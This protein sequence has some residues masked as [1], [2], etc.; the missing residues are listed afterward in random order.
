[1]S[2]RHS[3]LLLTTCVALIASAALLLPTA[4]QGQWTVPR[5]S[6]GHPDLQGN[7]TN[8]TITPIE[9]PQG[10]DAVLTWEEVASREGRADARVVAA[11]RP[12]DPD[13]APLE[14][15]SNVGGYNFV[16][17]DGGS[18]VA[19]V[20]GEPRSSLITNPTDGRRPALTPEG[21]RRRKE[22]RE[23]MARF[24]EY[25]NPENRTL[26]DRCLVSFGSH[27]GPPM[28]PNYGY[29]GNYTIVQTADYVMIH[30]EMVHDTRIIRLGEPDPLPDHMRPW[31]G[32]SWGRWEGNTLVVE[33]TNIHPL[34]NYPTEPIGQ[35]VAP[36]I[37]GVRPTATLRVTER[38]TRVD[39]QTIL[40]EF[41]VD[42]PTT[43]TQT[44]GGEVPFR[45][46][47]DLLYEYSCHEGNYAMSNILSGARYQERQAGGN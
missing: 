42:D 22:V 11:A 25:D 44:W 19:I 8:A 18:R 32:D 14:A 24:S 17:I 33:T 5:T 34:Q 3:T 37:W 12:S 21:E 46:Y 20:N 30:Y 2:I 26:A 40:Y 36:G 13:R 16:Y 6:D 31:F 43:Y 45:K 23:F 29:N 38:F 28:T 1:M 27:G 35:L 10:Q 41:T 9:R 47:N 4:A 39:E 15:G 7:W